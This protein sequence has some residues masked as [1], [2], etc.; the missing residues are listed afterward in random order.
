M[1]LERLPHDGQRPQYHFLPPRNWM[2]DPNGSIHWQG[3]YHLFYQHYPYGAYWNDMHWGHAVSKDLVHWEDKPIALYP[4]PDSVDQDG[5]FS[6]CAF[7]NNGV[8]TIMY[9]GVRGRNQLP[10]LAT[11]NDDLSQITKFAGNP[12]VPAPP[13]T[14]EVN[15]FRD[16]AVWR[17]GEKWYQLVGAG[18]KGVGGAALL[19]RSPD[20]INWEYVQP[21]LVGDPATTGTMWECPDFFPLGNKHVL[22]ISPIPLKKAIYFVGAYK[23][24][25]FTPEQRWS[26]D[27]GGHYYAPQ[28]FWDESGRRLIWGWL[29]EGRSREAQ[30]ASGWAGV[31]SLPRVLELDEAGYMRQSV[32]PELQRLR[33]E[34]TELG[35]MEL[36]AGMENRLTAVR[37][38]TF[39]L[40][41]EFDQLDHV[42]LVLKVR[43]SPDGEEETAV[44]F[45][46]E[47]GTLRIDRTKSSLDPETHKSEYHGLVP[48]TSQDSLTLHIFV[49]N[50]VI[51]VFA[52]GRTVLAGRVYPTREDSDG[53]WL[54]VEG[55]GRCRL[56]KLDIW[57]M[58]S[59]WE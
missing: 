50:S 17:E 2:N 41:A 46:S 57:Q 39:E 14:Y 16:H 18:F 33:G 21:I 24:H 51:E 31:M 56:K 4:T 26:M 49:D 47:Y 45:N 25:T 23:N 9:T 32:A 34:H 58:G 6:G 43:C 11:G 53:I 29:W 10:C 12:V 35:E 36:A 5:V 27:D 8:P 28:S 13:D 52:N 1:L 54:G 38:T 15:G 20:L 40:L 59:I 3:E 30:I 19:Y 48:L 44:T 22:I 55:N 7:D 37:S 42:D